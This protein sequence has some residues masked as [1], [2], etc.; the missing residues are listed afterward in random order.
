MVR[1]ALHGH[2]FVAVC[3]FV[4]VDPVICSYGIDPVVTSKV[5][6][7]DC[8]MVDFDYDLSS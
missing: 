2:A 1:R 6:A 4:V 3:Y 8:E 5:G 7:S